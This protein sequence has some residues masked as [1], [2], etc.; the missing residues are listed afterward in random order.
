MRVRRY[1]AASHD[2]VA[3]S[4]VF[5]TTVR[6]LQGQGKAKASQSLLPLSLIAIWSLKH[7]AVW[8]QDIADGFGFVTQRII[9]EWM[10][11]CNRERPHSAIGKATPDEA[12]GKGTELTKAA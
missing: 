7:K 4:H 1:R 9:D 2:L 12:C 3:E 8:L 6:C 5:V 11:F 10:H